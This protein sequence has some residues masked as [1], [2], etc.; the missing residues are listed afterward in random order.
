MGKWKALYEDDQRRKHT[1]TSIVEDRKRASLYWYAHKMVRILGRRFCFGL[2]A[3]V[4]THTF[5]A[6]ST[7]LAPNFEFPLGLAFSTV[8]CSLN[9]ELI[10]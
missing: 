4:R 1:P 10:V 9:G 5:L 2:E 7:I 8:P 3:Y 6:C